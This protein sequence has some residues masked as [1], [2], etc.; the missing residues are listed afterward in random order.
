MLKF[1]ALLTLVATPALADQLVFFQAPSKNIFC[2]IATGAWPE[3]RCDIMQMTSKI[4]PAPADCDLDYGHAFSI[5]RQDTKGQR[6]CAGDTVADQNSMTLGYGDHIDVGGFRC[7]SEKTG[8]TCT[9]P[10][11]HGFTIARATQKLF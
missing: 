1:A 4:P 5:G 3:A 10:A 2:M 6:V 11:G 8:M 9:N 7:S